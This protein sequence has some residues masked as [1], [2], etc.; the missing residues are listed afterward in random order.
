MF[1]NGMH[2]VLFMHCKLLLHKKLVLPYQVTWREMEIQWKRKRTYPVVC[3]TYPKF[4]SF[5][6]KFFRFYFVS[7]FRN[8]FVSVNRI[9]IFLLT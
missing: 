9:K 4:I 1:G 7:V 6:F 2:A 8:F 5:H 3:W